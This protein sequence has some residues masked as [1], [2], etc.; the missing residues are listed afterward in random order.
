[1]IPIKA[2]YKAKVNQQNVANPP[3]VIQHQK[4]TEVNCQHPVLLKSLYSWLDESA[5][6]KTLPL[7]VS[8]SILFLQT[9]KTKSTTFLLPFLNVQG[10]TGTR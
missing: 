9:I 2:R 8:A 6:K 4:F 1:M 5:G 7:S 3:N 10:L